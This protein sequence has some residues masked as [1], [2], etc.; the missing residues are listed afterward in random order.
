MVEQRQIAERQRVQGNAAYKH[1]QYSEALRCYE[2]GLEA[3]RQDMALHANAA[4]AAIKLKCYVQALEHCNKA[5][6]SSPC[7]LLAPPA[8]PL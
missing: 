5:S 1:G 3:Q 8:T 6:T 2:A 4:M 7:Q